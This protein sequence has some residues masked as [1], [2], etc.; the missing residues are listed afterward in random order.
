MARYTYCIFEETKSCNDCGK[1]D[2]CDLNPNKICNNCGKCLEK[3]GFDMRSVT[4]DGI[5]QEEEDITDF[6]M[7]DSTEDSFVGDDDYDSTDNTE[8]IELIDDI[9]GLRDLL[10]DEEKA[11]QYISEEYP[12][13]IRLRKRN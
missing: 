5:A 13:L 7:P 10:E 3:D 9:E 12:G 1:C 4:I 11:S 8:K 6:D 2:I